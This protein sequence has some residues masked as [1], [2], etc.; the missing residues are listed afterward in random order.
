MTTHCVDCHGGSDPEGNL[1]LSRFTTV[2]DVVSDFKT[3]QI[4]QSRLEAGD[5]PPKDADPQLSDDNREKLIS[6][7]KA[8]RRNEAVRNA[9]DPGLVLAR[10][11]SNSEY[12]YAI[13][14]LTGVDIRPTRDF[15]IDPANEAGFDNS[16]ESLTMTPALVRKYLDAAREVTDHLVLNP[17]GIAFAPHPVVTATDRDKYCVNRIIAFYDR[18]NTDLAD[19]FFAAWLHRTE[20]IGKPLAEIANDRGLSQRYLSTVWDILEGDA[21]ELGP[22]ANLQRRWR[23]LPDDSEDVEEA[24]RRCVALR[25]RVTQLREKLRFTFDSL[26]EAGIHQGSQAFVLWKNRQYADARRKCNHEPFVYGREDGSYGDLLV[27]EEEPIRSKVI[28]EFDRFCS[29]FPD[30][31]Y[32]RERG[33][34]YGNNKN[35]PNEARGRYLSAG[36]HSMMGY[37]RDDRPL[38]DLVLN[39]EQ[40]LE[41]DR[42]WWELDFVASA[43]MRQYSGMLWFERAESSFARERQFDFARP[44]S[45]ESASEENIRRYADLYLAKARRNEA[46]DVAITAI[47]DHFATINRQIRTVESAQLEAEPKHIQAVVEFAGRAFRRSLRSSEV[48]ELHDFYR[49]LRQNEELSHEDSIKDLVVSVLV[50]PQFSFRTD[51]A[52]NQD[53]IQELTDVEVAS[54]LSFFLWASVPDETLLS[55]AESGRLRDSGSLREQVTRMLAD[56]RSK[57][58]A[59]EFGGNWLDF[60]RFE[61]HNAVDRTQF[62]QFT[63]ELRQAM[64]EEPVRYLSDVIQRDRSILDLLYGTDTFVNQPLAKHYGMEQVEFG[65]NAWVHV[66]QADDYRRGGLLPMAIF[67]TKNAPGRRT[68]P[69]KRGYWVVRRLLGEEIPPPPPNVPEL[70]EDESELGDL[71]LREVL[72]R[73]RQHAS[74]AACHARFDSLGLVFE[75]FGPVGELRDRDLAGRP[76]DVGAMFP[77]SVSRSGVQ[78]LQ[79]YIRLERQDDFVDNFCRKLLTYSLGRSLIPSDDLLIEEMK[80]NLVENDHRFSSLVD[81]IVT[82]P[83]FLTKRGRIQSVART[84]GDSR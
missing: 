21:E 51:L 20:A 52:A 6:W 31:F 23:E 1:D 19:Y 45:R 53:D 76:V 22:I 17:D 25:Y 29:V 79:E 34:D 32:I 3:W 37:F 78:G 54:R 44:A 28:A 82:S 46:N 63:D 18:Q 81:T 16:G 8:L 55:L 43:P 2:E 64:F 10:R 75:D 7:L 47:Q 72:E 67:L 35:D 38:Y 42:L 50:S 24:R 30:A 74:C 71:T 60:R 12:N 49:Q 70:P 68:S 57:S 65:D 62:P 14:D 66:D 4:V 58:L 27:P 56:P 83:Q 39:K 36:F 15:P 40:Q 69:V 41:L 11:L 9:G 5:M 59:V 73:H 48:A 61:D 13:R 26:N 77:D 33:R 84:N 80:Q